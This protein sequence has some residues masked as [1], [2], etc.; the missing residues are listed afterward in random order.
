MSMTNDLIYVMGVE[1]HSM[2]LLKSLSVREE[3]LSTLMTSLLSLA[4]C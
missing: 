1:D 4:V 3:I 2:L